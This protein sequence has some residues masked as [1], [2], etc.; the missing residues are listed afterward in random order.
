MGLRMEGRVTL[1]TEELVSCV[2]SWRLSLDGNCGWALG[3][4]QCVI[5]IHLRSVFIDTHTTWMHLKFVVLGERH[6]PQ[7][8]L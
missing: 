1:V 4:Y 6:Q 7:K 2:Q 5:F 3:F 8:V